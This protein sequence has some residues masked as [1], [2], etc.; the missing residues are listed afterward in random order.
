VESHP[1]GFSQGSKRL[2]EVKIDK[3]G[4]LTRIA[5]FSLL[6]LGVWG[7]VYFFRRAYPVE[8]SIEY[9][10]K[11]IRYASKLKKVVSRL[12]NA[13]GEIARVEYLHHAPLKNRGRGIVRKQK[14]PL[15]PGKYR[16]SVWLLYR[17]G[18]QRLLQK[19]FRVQ[20]SGGTHY[21]YLSQAKANDSRM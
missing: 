10:Y 21:V 6:A 14:I 7:A 3:K 4:A 19:G 16:L 1:G 20:D 12:S 18:K 13:E 5:G 8:M 9:V 11:D 15:T 2:S 17:D